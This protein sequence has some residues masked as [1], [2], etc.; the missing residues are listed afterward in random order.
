MITTRQLAK[1]LHVSTRT[2]EGWRSR[3]IGPEYVTINNRVR[4]KESAVR[5]FTKKKVKRTK[6]AIKI[7]KIILS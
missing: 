6:R 7:I 3:G 2:V 1:Q 4:Y 5:K